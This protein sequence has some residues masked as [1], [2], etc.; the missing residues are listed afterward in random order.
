MNPAPIR[1]R[2]PEITIQVDADVISA[3]S[4][5][6]GEEDPRCL[7][8][9]LAPPALAAVYCLRP[10]VEQVLGDSELG[11]RLDR[12]LHTDQS[13]EFLT[14]VRSGDAVRVDTTLSKDFE[15]LGNRFL[16]C[17]S[18]ARLVSDGRVVCRSSASLMVVGNARDDST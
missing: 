9:Q 16:V 14:P 10:G 7:Q 17:Q 18:V 12:L 13:F 5:A 3:Y 11:L 6:I 2:Y 1:K 8:G 4:L 15:R